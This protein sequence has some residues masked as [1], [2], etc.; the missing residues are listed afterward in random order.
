MKLRVAVKELLRKLHIICG[1]CSRPGIRSLKDNQMFMVNGLTR[2]LKIH[3][4]DGKLNM[5]ANVRLHDATGQGKILLPGQKLIN[6][7]KKS[8]RDI[9]TFQA[10]SVMCHM[11][12]SQHKHEVGLFS[13]DPNRYPKHKEFSMGGVQTIN[14]KE[15]WTILLSV[16]IPGITMVHITPRKCIS[17]SRNISF[18]KRY[19]RLEIPEFTIRAT[20]VRQLLRVLRLIKRETRILKIRR[21]GDDVA[22]LMGDVMFYTPVYEEPWNSAEF[23]NNFREWIETIQCRSSF[24]NLNAIGNINAI[25]GDKSRKK[26]SLETES[27]ITYFRAGIDLD[28]PEL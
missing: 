1:S 17:T 16:Y 10:Y 11:T 26:M 7:I 15:F 5:L 19:A 8:K 14:P 20:A 24:P 18:E 25:V 3:S 13:P 28:N 6:M 22:F 23:E 2:S 9:A 4:T 12:L 21:V 27:D